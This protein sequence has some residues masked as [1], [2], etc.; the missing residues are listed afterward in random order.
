[1]TSQ[2]ISADDK[3]NE[4]IACVT[5][6]GLQANLQIT[7]ACILVR[8]AFVIEGFL[9]QLDAFT[10]KPICVNTQNVSPHNTNIINK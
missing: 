4:V 9:N 8:Y 7:L 1:M 2:V 3:C 6:T 5:G 10:L